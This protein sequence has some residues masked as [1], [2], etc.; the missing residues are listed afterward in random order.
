MAEA[1]HQLLELY[2]NVKVR[3]KEEISGFDQEKMSEERSG[4]E[5]AGLLDLINYVKESIEI[6]MNVKVED[7]MEMKKLDEEDD[8]EA[9][10][11]LN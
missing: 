3:S 7:Y 1:K 8:R 4:L 10:K 9:K 11:R 5:K 6:L 2:L